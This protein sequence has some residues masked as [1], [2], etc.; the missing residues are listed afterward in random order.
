VHLGDHWD[1]GSLS[2]YEKAGGLKLEGG[3]RS[4]RSGNR[5]PQS[6]ITC[7]AIT[8]TGSTER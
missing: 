5:G 4:G 1:M 7:S 3:K 2:S 6:V 8:R